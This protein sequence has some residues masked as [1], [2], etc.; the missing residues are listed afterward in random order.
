MASYNWDAVPEAEVKSFELMPE[1]DYLLQVVDVDTTKETRNGDEMWRLTLKVMNEGKF[2]NRNVWDNWVFSVGGIK[3]IKLIRKNI[4]LNIVGTFQPTSEEI[5]GRVILATV[6][7]E[8]YNG[9][10]QNKIPFDGYK[11]IDDLGMEQ[12]AKGLEDEFHKAKSDM[13]YDADVDTE[14][15]DVEA[16]F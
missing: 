11:M 15:D 2:Y 13:S 7:Q 3:R 14:M 10:V 6:I 8:E 9:K 1:A 4:G 12:Y 16:P 5:L